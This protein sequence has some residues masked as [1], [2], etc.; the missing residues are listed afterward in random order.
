MALPRGRRELKKAKSL[1]GSLGKSNFVEYQS[2]LA[3]IPKRKNVP[4]LHAVYFGRERLGHYVR[5]SSKRYNAYDA[6][7]RPLGRFRGRSAAYAAVSKAARQC[8]F[9]K[10][11]RS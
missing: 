4:L 7:N 5:I 6:E 2:V 3:P 1:A 11:R 8:R 9:D 10:E